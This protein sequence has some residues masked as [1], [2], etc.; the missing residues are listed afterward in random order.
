MVQCW[1]RDADNRPKFSS[2]FNLL[3]GRTSDGASQAD[4]P[5][6]E[7]KM[8][9]YDARVFNLVCIDSTVRVLTDVLPGL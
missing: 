6:S 3:Q 2:L 9:Q 4:Q 5:K 7:V 8:V 1:D